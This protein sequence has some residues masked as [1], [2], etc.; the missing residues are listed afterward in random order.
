[1]YKE[2]EFREAPFLLFFLQIRCVSRINWKRV[3]SI[4]GTHEIRYCS[5]EWQ[6]ADWKRHK[7]PYKT[8]QQCQNA[9]Y[10]VLTG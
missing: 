7:P 5:K 3:A 10:Y 6:R 8:T 2:E 4:A 9:P 1:M